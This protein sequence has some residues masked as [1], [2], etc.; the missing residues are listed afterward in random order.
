MSFAKPAP[1]PAPRAPG[2]TGPNPSSLR[3]DLAAAADYLTALSARYNVSIVASGS[4]KGTT[5]SAVETVTKG[6][7]AD[8]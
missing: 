6:A 3:R 2:D 5:V 1:E 8:V 4:P 7:A